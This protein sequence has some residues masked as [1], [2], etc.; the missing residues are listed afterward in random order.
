MYCRNDST[1]LVCGDDTGGDSQT[2]AEV[3]ITASEYNACGPT[4]CMGDSG[5]RGNL[6]ATKKMKTVK[7]KTCKED[8]EKEKENCYKQQNSAKM[9]QSE[10]RVPMSYTC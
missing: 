3:S 2:A 10:R 5:R 9:P 4:A 8:E 1:L 7:T 6:Q